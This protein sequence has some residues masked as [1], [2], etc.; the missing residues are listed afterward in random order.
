[1]TWVRQPPR[2]IVPIAEV[3]D[4]LRTSAP[5][6]M[7]E[8]Y[9][10][11]IREGGGSIPRK[12]KLDVS[13][14]VSALPNVALFAVTLPDLCIYRVVGETWKQRI[15]M[16]P[17]GKNYLDFV[18]DER[19]ASAKESLRDLI[20]IPSAFRVIIEQVYSGGRK[21]NLEAL[22][23]P[24]ASDESGIDGFTLFASELIAP[25]RFGPGEERVVL[26]ANVIERDLI[27]LGHGVNREFVDMVRPG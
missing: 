2:R 12:A 19:K 3:P 26:G 8:A 24:L 22:A 10:A 20:T 16:N 15:G 17:V 5:R 18:A 11:M 23:V 27:D 6:V 9:A 14:F 4:L 21:A 13:R 7:A 25:I 1:M